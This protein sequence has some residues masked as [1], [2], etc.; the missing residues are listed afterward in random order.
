MEEHVRKMLESKP[1]LSEIITK[2]IRH[3]GIIF[4]SKLFGGWGADGESDVDVLLP[5]TFHY[6]W[7]D[8]FKLGGVYTQDYMTPDCEF[9][10]IYVKMSDSKYIHNLLLFKADHH[11]RKWKNATDC[12]MKLKASN[13]NIAVGIKQKKIRVAIFEALKLLFTET[14]L[15]LKPQTFEEPFFDY[16]EEI[17]F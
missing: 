15:K 11:F 13:V 16:D 5:P 6:T 7:T 4:G 14:P 1:P 9:A 12:L 3:D 17:P 10:S 8:L 2:Q